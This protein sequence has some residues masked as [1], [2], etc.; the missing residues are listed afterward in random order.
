MAVSDKSGMKKLLELYKDNMILSGKSS[1][2]LSWEE[3]GAASVKQQ[4]IGAE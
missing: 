4:F 2:K 3:N 1:E